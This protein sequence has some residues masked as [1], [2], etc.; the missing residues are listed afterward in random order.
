ML[1]GVCWDGFEIVMRKSEICGLLRCV[2]AWPTVIRGV[3]VHRVPGVLGGL[4]AG[5]L[6]VGEVGSLPLASMQPTTNLSNQSDQCCCDAAADLSLVFLRPSVGLPFLRGQIDK[7]N[8]GLLQ[9]V[10]GLRTT[11]HNQSFLC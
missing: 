6:I 1:R 4:L 8:C 7:E 5:G 9:T 10:G 11:A 2:L 3:C